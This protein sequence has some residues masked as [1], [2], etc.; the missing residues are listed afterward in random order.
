MAN[1]KA[2]I[3]SRLLG[4]MKMSADR[5]EVSEEGRRR[6][7]ENESR[8]YGKVGGEPVTRNTILRVHPRFS[9]A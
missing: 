1:L 8:V 6:K 2:R 5:I 9:N 7:K 4:V 3:R